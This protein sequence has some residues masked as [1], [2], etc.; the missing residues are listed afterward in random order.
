VEECAD[1][2]LSMLLNLFR[3][4]H[5]L[6]NSV[7]TKLANAKQSILS[8]FNNSNANGVNSSNT[9]LNSIIPSTPE[10][11]RDLAQGCLRLRGQT[12]GI[13]GFGKIGIAVAQRAKAFGFNILFFDPFVTDGLDK[14]IGGVTRCSSLNDLLSQSDCVTLHA[15]L[16]EQTYHLLNE[17]TFKLMKQGSFLINTA[18]SALVD[19]MALANA[20][21][22]GPLKGAALDVFQVDS[23]HPLNGPLKDAPNLIV[24]PHTSFY[25]DVSSKEMREMAAQEVRRG[26]L[27]KTPLTLRNCVNKDLLLA[28]AAAA[29]SSSNSSTVV[30]GNNHNLLNNLSNT[31]NNNN[32]SNNRSGNSPANLLGASMGNSSLTAASLLSANSNLNSSNQ[33]AQLLAQLNY[34]KNANFDQFSAAAALNG[35]PP[36]FLSY[37]NPLN[38]AAAVAAAA[39]SSSSPSPSPTSSALSNLQQQQVNSLSSILPPGLMSSSQSNSVSAALTAALMDPLLSKQA[40]AQLVAA[41]AAAAAQQ[42]NFLMPEIKSDNNNNNNN[43]S[44]DGN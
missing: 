1:A 19:E 3:R 30:N 39:S 12:L 25:S 20:L 34:L 17:S 9:I 18:Q 21:K 26:L 28:A 14:S 7:Q 6:A 24:T 42:Q 8:S 32:N 35:M 4:T 11:T 31:N 27:N 2:T 29:A 36:S 40:Q 37:F 43:N 15:Q 41:A 22:Y 33:N 10:Q 38:A 16:N 23:F 13:V 5:W 44:N